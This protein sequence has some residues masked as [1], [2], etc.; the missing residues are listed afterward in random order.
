MLGDE[1]RS[2]EAPTSAMAAAMRSG[3]ILAPTADARITR[4][5][6]PT[7]R[8]LFFQHAVTFH[9]AQPYITCTELPTSPQ[10]HPMSF[11]AIVFIDHARVCLCGKKCTCNRPHISHKSR[12][13]YPQFD[14]TASRQGN[15]VWSA[16]TMALYPK[17]RLLS[18]AMQQMIMPCHDSTMAGM[19]TMTRFTSETA[20]S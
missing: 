19:R 7:D 13:S 18:R 20:F 6:N 11:S 2:A 14:S 3:S 5:R 16:P 9:Q 1:G 12:S 8:V 17:C 15:F 4:A 10:L